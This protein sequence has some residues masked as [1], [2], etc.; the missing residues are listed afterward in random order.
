MNR[1]IISLAVFA[2]LFLFVAKAQETE[3]FTHGQKQYQD[4]LTLYNNQQ[5]QAAQALF[6]KVGVSTDDP[7]IE[8]NSKYYAANAAIRLDQRGADKLMES[9]VERYPTSTKRNAAFLDV[10]DYYFETGKYPY[11]LKWY[12]KVD[13]GAISKNDEERFNFNYGYALYA[14]NRSKEAGKYLELVS[15]SEQYGSQAKYYLGYIAY[16]Q[17]DYDQASAR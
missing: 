11:A 12:R 3:L 8:A 2:I 17:D 5:Y 10:A 7:T 16:E 14:S 15:E 9:F 13:M 4:A 1:K 6:D